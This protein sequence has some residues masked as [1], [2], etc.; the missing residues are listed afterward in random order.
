MSYAYSECPCT[1]RSTTE[2]VDDKRVEKSTALRGN[3]TPG[4][5]KHRNGNDPGYHYPINAHLS[6]AIEYIYKDTLNNICTSD[7][8]QILS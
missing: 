4:G 3:R 6:S 2:L 7:F 5:S 1:K 8:F